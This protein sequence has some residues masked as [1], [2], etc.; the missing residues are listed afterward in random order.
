MKNLFLVGGGPGR[1]H[2]VSLSSFEA[3][4]SILENKGILFQSIIIDKNGDWVYEKEIL[5]E[6]GGLKLLQEK[7]ALVYQHIHGTYGEDG[8]FISKLEKCGI[9]YIGSGSE[10]MRITIDKYKTEELLKQ[11]AILT[12]SSLVI[13]NSSKVTELHFNFPV[14]IKPKNEGSSVALSKAENTEELVDVLEKTGLQYGDMLVQDFVKGREFTC[15]VVEIEGK[16]VALVP[17]EVIL[18]KGDMFDYDAKYTVGGSIEITPAD[19]HQE[20]TDKIKNIAIEVHVVCGCKDISR[21]D[22]I[23]KDGGEIVVLEINTVPGMTKTSFI[24][25]QLKASGY[26]IEQFVEGMIKKYS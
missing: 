6:E 15:G 22:M 10:S 9:A 21:T 20:L 25:A 8:E 18:T 5:S 16:L 12:T 4:K 2:E 23:M 7:N 13:N 3:T 17:T 24:P 1:E 14:I 19:I 26:S 11:K